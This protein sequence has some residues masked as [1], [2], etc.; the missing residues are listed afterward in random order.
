[1]ANT[2]RLNLDCK[3]SEL[4]GD[5]DKYDYP[6]PPP[7]VP[8]Y[9]FPN[10]PKGQVW[11]QQPTGGG[12]LWVPVSGI[13]PEPGNP[14][15]SNPLVKNGDTV[16]V[17]LR[18]QSNPGKSIMTVEIV[19]VFGRNPGNSDPKAPPMAS[20]FNHQGG[21]NQTTFN[22]LAGQDPLYAGWFVY[23][24]PLVAY[25]ADPVNGRP[26]K[27]TCFIGAKVTY[28][29]FTHRQFD[30]DPDLEVDD[31]GGPSLEKERP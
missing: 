4:L 29:D 10:L 25:V 14:K 1:M 7:P 24:L 11:W 3:Y 22:G 5:L 30:I 8:P 6:P 13:P 27:F 16:C 2:F 19:V 21:Y 17:A 12:A 28:T 20:P 26:A 15:H 31:Y 9:A 23:N 18:D